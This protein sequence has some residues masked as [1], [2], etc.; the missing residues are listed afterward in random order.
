[1]QGTKETRGKKNDL[2]TERKDQLPLE[3]QYFQE[4]VQG[5]CI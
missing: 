2:G 3:A 4:M 5:R 1:M